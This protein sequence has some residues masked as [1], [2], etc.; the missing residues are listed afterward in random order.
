M[1]DCGASGSVI[2]RTLSRT[3]SLLPNVTGTNGSTAAVSAVNAL[4]NLFIGG[5]GATSTAIVPM[6]DPY[7][8]AVSSSSFISAAD[9]R[10][11]G[12]T[13]T[14]NTAVTNPS[15]MNYSHVAAAI[16][17]HPSQM[18]SQMQNQM[19]SQM[20][21]QMQ[22]QMQHQMQNQMHQQQGEI[23]AQMIHY[24][25]ISM[26]QMQ[27]QQHLQ[28]QKQQQQQQQQQNQG[29]EEANAHVDVENSADIDSIHTHH[30]IH[31]HPNMKPYP[32]TNYTNQKSSMIDDAAS[33]TADAYSYNGRDDVDENGIFDNIL[34]DINGGEEDNAQSIERLAKAWAEAEDE[35]SD[36]NYNVN[37]NDGDYYSNNDGGIRDYV[38]STS[39]SENDVLDIIDSSTLLPQAQQLYDEGQV[40]DAIPIL[41]RHLQ[42]IDPNDADAWALLGR[43]HA[44]NDEDHKAIACLERSVERDPFEPN[45]RLELGVSYINELDH[46]RALEHLRCWATHNPDHQ[47]HISPVIEENTATTINTTTEGSALDELRTLLNNLL[48]DASSTPSSISQAHE[49]LGVALNV[50]RDYDLASDHLRTA[51]V[52]RQKNGED[53]TSNN[54]NNNNNKQI[55]ALWNRLGATL[56][57]GGRSEEALDAYGRALSIRPRYA[58]GWLNLAIAHG[59]L[60]NHEEAARCHLQV[61]SLHPNAT[62]VWGYLRIALTCSERWDLL[63][64][65]SQ[66]G[67]EGEGWGNVDAFREHFDFV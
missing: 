45:V 12:A 57:N 20:Q 53:G 59:N 66:Q 34:D 49:V 17:Q 8:A 42:S 60:G 41:E 16:Q 65:L 27:Q 23:Q 58:R 62:Q 31:T 1:A 61:L 51:L 21:N 2:D 44:E 29:I 10:V 50:S 3:S 64:L 36:G 46:G 52:E 32:D 4:G 22:H 14:N 39:T 6:I 25:Q 43:C 28:Q 5:G 40:S 18:K 56:A 13:T 33:T 38:F 54:N 24:Q 15:V 30:S 35:F 63:P 47:H 26:L 7:T 11:M 9:P 19:Q 48:N 67:E 37:N 55:H